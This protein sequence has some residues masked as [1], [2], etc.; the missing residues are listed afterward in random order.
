MLEAQLRALIADL[1]AVGLSGDEAFLVTVKRMGNVDSLSGDFARENRDRLWKQLVLVPADAGVS[2]D[3][4]PDSK[5]G[6]RPDAAPNVLTDAKPGARPAGIQ[7]EAIVAFF[8]AV[9]AAVVIKLP[10]FFGI[11]LADEAAGFYLRNLSLF[12]LPL[13]TVYF[14]WRRRPAPGMLPWLAGAFLVAAILA[15]AYPFVP[16]GHT[17]ILLA[18]HLPIAIWLVVGIA[19]S[20]GRWRE[21]E[22]RM[23]F[24]RFSGELFIYYVLIAL[25]GGVLIA[26]MSLIFAAIGVDLEPIFESWLLPCGAAGGVIIGSY[27]VET[28]QGLAE[29]L[30][31]MLT[32]LFTPFF[33]AMLVTFLAVML[34]T[35]RGIKIEREVLIAFDLLLVVV[36][37]LLLFSIS[38]RNPQS[39]PGPFDVAQVVLILSALLADAFALWAIAAR[40]TEF[41][42]SP[43]RV[44]ALGANIVLLINLAWSA[45][46]YLR[47]LRG[48]VP[49]TRLER[50]QTAYVPVYAAWAAIVTIVFPPLFGWG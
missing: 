11:R 29:N 21:H 7:I 25:G 31:P 14:A 19:Y 40:I 13:L 1:S 44:A 12:V 33:A 49:F 46:L 32:R 41:G 35:G 38:A 2:V 30:A 9:A 6:V 20:G 39:C 45:V 16:K 4:Q 42:A 37:G 17:E 15:N 27:L 48:S 5:P 22:G 34:W 8:L 24:I 3:A 10:A 43:N 18:L 36:L 23:D 28:R 26:F 47:F 50:W